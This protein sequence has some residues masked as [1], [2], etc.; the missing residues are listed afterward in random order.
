MIEARNQALPS[1]KRKSG[2]DLLDVLE[3]P[4]G[5]SGASGT[6]FRGGGGRFGGG[7]A[8]GDWDSPS[9]QPGGFFAQNEPA[10][11]TLPSEP[12]SKLGK[13]FG[14]GLDDEA[15]LALLL[16]A[17]AAFAAL[18]ASAYLI[19]TAPVLLAELMVDGLLLAGLYKKFRH[20][21]ET[22]WLQT[23]LRKTW[24]LALSVALV[25]CGVGYG[26]PRVSPEAKTIGDVFKSHDER[27]L[28][29]NLHFSEIRRRV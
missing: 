8:S 4:R 22:A 12:P 27:N 13:L 29:T 17:I 10:S 21:D 9:A 24:A 14:I 26:L 20:I 5:G 19:F 16:I 28:R 15:L 7:G 3:F 2:A 11:Q 23:A 25:F 18:A 6:E 1:R